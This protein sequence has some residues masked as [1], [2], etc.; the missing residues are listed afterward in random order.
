M[1]QS[2][3]AGSVHGCGQ[4]GPVDP[5]SDEYARKPTDQPLQQRFPKCST[6]P[7]AVLCRRWLRPL[8]H[9]VSLFNLLSHRNWY[10]VYAVFVSFR[11]TN[12][13]TEQL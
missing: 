5:D 11:G 2:P 6:I 3:H 1:Q 7:I 10:H 12:T 9:F 8:N 4:Y 13:K